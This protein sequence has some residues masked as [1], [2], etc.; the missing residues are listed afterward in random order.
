MFESASIQIS[1]DLLYTCI[2]YT[3]SY[4]PYPSE[5]VQNTVLNAS[6]SNTTILKTIIIAIVDSVTTKCNINVVMN[7]KQVNKSTILIPVFEKESFVG[8]AA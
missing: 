7:S 8:A 1:E 3:Y 5:A 6:K 2:K 4:V